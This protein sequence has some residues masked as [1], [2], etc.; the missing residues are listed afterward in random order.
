[1]LFKTMTS[2][3]ELTKVRD[4]LYKLK[5][6]QCNTFSS[7]SEDIE[8]HTSKGLIELAKWGEY[9]QLVFGDMHTSY[10]QDYKELEQWLKDN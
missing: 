7:V 8:F 6:T 4:N 10:I 5:K 1:M 9:P 3:Y 2:E